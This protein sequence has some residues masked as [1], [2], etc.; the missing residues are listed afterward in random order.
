MGG[1]ARR[2]PVGHV[3]AARG[4]PLGAVTPDRPTASAPARAR[5]RSRCTPSGGPGNARLPL[6]RLPLLQLTVVTAVRAPGW[7]VTV[8]AHNL[9]APVRA[10]EPCE[11]LRLRRR[12]SRAGWDPVM[13]VVA[14]LVV[15]FGALVQGTVGFGS[16]SRSWRRRYRCWSAPCFRSCTGAPAHRLRTA[17]GRGGLRRGRHG[18]RDRGSARGAALSGRARPAGARDAGCVLRRGV[19]ALD[20]RARRRRRGPVRPIG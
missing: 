16:G 9:L 20:P 1:T 7:I 18:L 12:G 10:F 5:R 11:P 17:R 6:P 13:I 15:A 4:P 8:P 19:P 2:R 3:P 14:G